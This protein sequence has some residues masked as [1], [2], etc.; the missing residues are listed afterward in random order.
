MPPEATVPVRPP[1]VEPLEIMEFGGVVVRVFA[2]SSQPRPERRARFEAMVDR[3]A[4]RILAED[5]TNQSLA[6]MDA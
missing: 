5:L 6:R 1:S 4:A 2:N 3:V